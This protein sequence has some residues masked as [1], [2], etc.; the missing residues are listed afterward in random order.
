[1]TCINTLTWMHTHPHEQTLTH[2]HLHSS[3]HRRI[4]GSQRYMSIHRSLGCSHRSEHT[5][6][7]GS[8]NTRSHLRGRN[9][10]IIPLEVC[11]AAVCAFAPM[12]AGLHTTVYVCMPVQVCTHVDEECAVR[13]D[14]LPADSLNTWAE[15]IIMRVTT[16]W[17]TNRG[18]SGREGTE[19]SAAGDV[20]SSPVEAAQAEKQQQLSHHRIIKRSSRAGRQ[21]GQGAVQYEWEMRWRATGRSITSQREHKKLLFYS[22]KTLLTYFFLFFFW[23]WW[24]V[25]RPYIPTHILLNESYW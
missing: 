23:W 8:A 14:Q 10:A 20:I 9:R 21:W 4:S 22:F 25:W 7:L 17:I 16:Q 12:C 15:S 6:D 3:C 11:T 18:S 5:D 24:C 2:T 1:M 13:G 19:L